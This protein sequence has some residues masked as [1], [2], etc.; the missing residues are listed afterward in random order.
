MGAFYEVA[1][2][3]FGTSHSGPQLTWDFEDEYSPEQVEKV[4]DE[5]RATKNFWMGLKPM[6]ATKSLQYVHNRADYFFITSRI[7]TK[8]MRAKEQACWALRNWFGITYPTVIVVD[9]PGQKAR[10][11]Q[12]L[13]LDSFIDDK[14]ATIIDMHEAGIKSYAHLAPYNSSSPFPEGVIPVESLDEYLEAELGLK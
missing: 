4:W 5:I 3:M 13:E 7:D 12:A 6:P 14:R 11:A 10:I 8:G 2:P 9:E 1:N